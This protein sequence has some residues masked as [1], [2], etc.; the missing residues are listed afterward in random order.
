MIVVTVNKF[1]TVKTYW[2]IEV[3][4]SIPAAC[5]PITFLTNNS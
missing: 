4:F 1:G 5:I 2:S 3:L